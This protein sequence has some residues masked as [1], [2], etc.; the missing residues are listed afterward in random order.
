MAYRPCLLVLSR[1]TLFMSI[2]QLVLRVSVSSLLWLV[3]TSSL[4]FIRLADEH[5]LV[6]FTRSVLNFVH[7]YNIVEGLFCAT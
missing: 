3:C 1:S 2:N 6:S 5:W 4:L 7:W